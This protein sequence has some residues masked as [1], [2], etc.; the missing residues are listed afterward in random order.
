M[1]SLRFHFSFMFALILGGAFAN[2]QGY[3]WAPQYSVGLSSPLAQLSLCGPLNTCY[4][5]QSSTDFTNWTTLAV[6]N[7]TIWPAQASLT[8][9]QDTTFFRSAVLGTWSLGGFSE[10]L[11]LR[12]DFG[13]IGNGR[14][15]DTSAL[16]AVFNSTQ[17]HSNAVV[18]VPPG[19]YQL[20]QTCTLGNDTGGI[21]PRLV[22]I[23]L[24]ASKTIFRWNG[25][26]NGPIFQFTG[27][28]PEFAGICIQTTNSQVSA[29]AYTASQ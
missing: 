5:V 27:C 28:S 8:V 26:G 2:A 29:I 24:D 11:D 1:I 19:T 22:L 23:G 12:R 16:Q 18:F 17:V 7:P 3:G 6:L 14:A 20:T 15:D 10:A 13:A 21:A 9:T 4:A 25:S